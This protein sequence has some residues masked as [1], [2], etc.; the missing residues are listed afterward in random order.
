[1]KHNEQDLITAMYMF[2]IFTKVFWKFDF[3]QSGKWQNYQNFPNLMYILKC[4]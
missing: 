3:Y 2:H 4:I 1:M